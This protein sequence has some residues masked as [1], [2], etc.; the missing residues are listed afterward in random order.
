MSTEQEQAEALA[1][2]LEAPPGTPIPE[3]LDPDVVESMLALRPELAP[4]PAFDLDGLL[5]EVSEGPLAQQPVVEHEVPAPANRGGAGL[6][7]IV[8]GVAALAAAMMLTVTLSQTA[9]PP[10]AEAPLAQSASMPRAA[11]APIAEAEPQLDAVA[12]LDEADLEEEE[13]ALEREELAQLGYLEEPAAKESPKAEAATAPPP[14]APR[15]TR[16]ASRPSASSGSS[17]TSLG[18]DTIAG[19]AQQAGGASRSD[20]DFDA[21][22]TAARAQQRA[23]RL[24]DAAESLEPWVRQ[25]AAQGQQAAAYAADLFLSAGLPER[26]ERI[27]SLGLS[28]GDG[29]GNLVADLQRLRAMAR[30]DAAPMD[31]IEAAPASDPP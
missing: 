23:G 24:V 8:G 7:A 3:G 1:A 25:P 9:A 15:R 5:D 21:A 10:S 20:S 2:W 27:A 16:A 28:L 6:W 4:A 13:E 18:D 29:G 14:P 19:G 31:A 12:D 30:A 11:E 22:M 17:S 26:A